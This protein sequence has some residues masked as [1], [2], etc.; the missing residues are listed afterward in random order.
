[1]TLGSFFTQ[2]FLYPSWTAADLP[3][4]TGKTAVVTGASAGIGKETVRELA[5]KG[6][7]VI[8][9]GRNKEKTL[10]AIEEI[11]QETGNTLL[12]FVQCDMSDLTSVLLASE[13][14]IKKKLPIDILVNN[15]GIFNADFAL[16]KQGI[17][18]TFA[19]NVFGL[20]LLTTKL[21]PVLLQT[22]KPRIV[23]VSSFLHMAAKEVDLE[24]INDPQKFN[25]R[26]AYCASKLALQHYSL[27]LAEK[28]EGKA[29]VNTLHPGLVKTEIGRKDGKSPD[30]AFMDYLS[31]NPVKGA[32]TTL[33][34]AGDPD[35][36]RLGYNGQYFVPY[37]S[38]AQASP[39]ALDRV[40][41][42]K[43]WDAVEREIRKHI[44]T[45]RL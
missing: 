40:Q 20:V 37:A 10:A 25:G 2:V 1:M 19:T 17:E 33:Y 14:I 36:E 32:I 23:N 41:A 11:K 12:E 27:L 18:A 38:L 6:C 31:I 16:S 9:L 39:Q 35:I 44:S 13:T 8:S 21:L 15:A 3:D 26:S 7:K 45:F 42:Q 4:L 30:P 24:S 43:T 29:L 28:L 5:R 22:K 34:V